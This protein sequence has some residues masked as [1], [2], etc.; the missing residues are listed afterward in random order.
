M[1]Y[2][3][4]K[5]ARDFLL[6]KHEIYSSEQKQLRYLPQSVKLEE[7]ANPQMVRATMVV[8]STAVVTF[9][10]WASVTSIN[11][12]ASAKGEV[13]PRGFVQVVQHWDGGIVSE[14][15]TGEGEI[16]EEGQIL[17][18]LDDG[19]S[20]YNLAQAEAAYSR[21][22]LQ[23]ERL[24]ALLDGRQLD[25][26]NLKTIDSNIQEQQR[27]IFLSMIEVRAKEKAV[28]QEK[29]LQKEMLLETQDTENIHGD[30]AQY[31][32]QLEALSARYREQDYKELESIQVQIQQMAQDI[33][34]LRDK[35][36]RMDVRSPIYGV[37]KGFS[38]N[39]IGG[40][41]HPGASLMEIVPL[42]KSLVVE[43]RIL[44][45]DIGYVRLGQDVRVRIGSYNFARYGAIDGYLEFISATTFLDERGQAYYRGRI[46]LVQD[47]VGHDFKNPHNMILPGMTAEVDI[48][49]GRKTIMS[50]LLRPIHI[51]LKLA[52]SEH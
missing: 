32:T 12:V 31:K 40:V 37:V 21:L 24:L 3:F 34:L 43:A 14:I 8:I 4:Y 22:Q 17:L 30:I 36:L 38:M 46:A 13:V 18:R 51:S 11:E 41:V 16:V 1:V 35:V 26:E 50:Y 10:L 15:L 47:Y 5:R 27:Q 2:K 6:R 42:G 45:Q 19:V 20:R 39:T 7:A 25:F 28:L 33:Q 44:P 52:M 29:I 23:N 48:L 49:T 9:I